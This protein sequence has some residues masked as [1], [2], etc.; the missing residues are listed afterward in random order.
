VIGTQLQIFQLC[1][2]FQS[3]LILL[4]AGQALVSPIQ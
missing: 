4:L 3:V 2:R 1:D